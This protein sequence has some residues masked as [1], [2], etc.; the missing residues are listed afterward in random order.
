MDYKRKQLLDMM[1]AIKDVIEENRDIINDLTKFED[2]YAIFE[3]C[4]KNVKSNYKPNVL[5]KDPV[6]ETAKKCR[7][8]LINFV[9]QYSKAM[10]D[11]AE[12]THYAV[13]KEKVKINK[14]Q[15]AYFQKPRLC[16]KALY[17][18]NQAQSRLDELLA[19]GITKE[20]QKSFQEL[21]RAYSEV[22]ISS[23]ENPR[24]RHSNR[25]NLNLQYGLKMLVEMDLIVK[26]HKKQ[27]SDFYQKWFNARSINKLSIL[28]AQNCS[29]RRRGRKSNRVPNKR[30]LEVR[31][32]DS[33]G[34]LLY[35]ATVIISTISP[36]NWVVYRI[37]TSGK[38]KTTILPTGTYSVKV[39]KEGWKTLV[40][41]FDVEGNMNEILNLVLQ[42]V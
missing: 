34:Q 14:S 12:S 39:S 4:L 11:Y 21:I 37:A 30:S 41:E 29:K 2:H 32:K 5:V 22:N 15:L 23:V 26:S 36:K 31:I 27:H 18:Y 9:L 8:E 19:F 24:P 35:D 10:I 6:E 1:S 7:K 40:L 3:I 25:K 13:L 20:G 16:D 38:F 42:K 28:E 17:L 33:E